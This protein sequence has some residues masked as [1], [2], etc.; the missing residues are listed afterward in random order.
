MMMT[1]DMELV[2]EYAARQSEEAFAAL[3][4]RHLNLV[5]SVALRQLG[6]PHLAEEVTQAAFIILARKAGSLGPKTI[7]SAWLCRTAQYVAARAVRTQRRRQCREQE[8]YMQSLLNQPEPEISRWPDIAPLLDVAMAG[9]GEKDHSAI[10]L[11]F[12]EGKDLKQVGA[13]LGVN[14]NAA[15]TRVSRAVEKMRRFFSKRGVTLSVAAITGAVAAN[16]IQAAPVALAKS[17]T[18]VAVAKGATASVPTLGLVKAGLKW[19]TW[20][21]AKIAVVAGGIVLLSTGVTMMTVGVE[22]DHVRGATRGPD[23]QGA[24]EGVT[25]L[26][27][28]G[29]DIGGVRLGEKAQT[30]IV[31]A[32]DKTNGVYGVTGDVIDLGI[33]NIRISKIMYDFPTVRIDIEGWGSFKAKVNGEGT[34]MKFQVGDKLVV[35]ARTNAPD[36]VPERL[37]ESDFSP[38]NGADLQG[39]WKGK[40]GGRPDGA[41]VNWKIAG[42]TDG[43]YRGEMDRPTLY[44]GANHW[45]VFV[46]YKDSKVTLKPMSGAGLFLGKIN[47]DGTEIVGTWYERGALRPMTLKRAEYVPE[48]PLPESAYAFSSKTDLQGH[49]K[50]VCAVKVGPV[51]KQPLDLDIAKLSDGTFLSTLAM[52]WCALEGMGDPLSATDFKYQLQNVRLEW[53][54]L[55][56]VFD[57]KLTDG[58]LTGKWIQGGASIPMIFE[59]SQP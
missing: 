43:T 4:S 52:P 31:F 18:A 51:M 54:S 13:A 6:D 48:S 57:G 23:I 12:F 14:E 35:Y 58:K 8:T 26:D 21:K 38:H 46:S 29:L 7:V 16:S 24:W 59:R 1:E 33:K 47:G 27:A 39:Y 37:A 19:I 41:P 49:W 45:P 11:R 17:V 32:I 5:Y 20:A 34:E 28:P 42:Q 22:S 2:R 25:T 56:A 53:K 15:K 9:L 36:T 30:R 3:V 55:G 40:I 50:T 10:V 44:L